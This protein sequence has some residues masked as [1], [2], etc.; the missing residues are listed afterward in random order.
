MK[1]KDQILFWKNCYKCKIL[2]VK[3]I[4]S[5]KIITKNIIKYLKPNLNF[6]FRKWFKLSLKYL[7]KIRLLK[8]ELFTRRVRFYALVKVKDSD[9]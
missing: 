7:N 1:K 2:L 9:K 4:Y 5:K 3:F 8:G 6:F